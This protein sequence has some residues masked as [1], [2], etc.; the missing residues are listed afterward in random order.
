MKKEKLDH[1]LVIKRG[2][3]TFI[4]SESPMTKTKGAKLMLKLIEFERETF[5]LRKIRKRK[6]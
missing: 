6:K 2:K 1:E 4:H 5:A 3:N